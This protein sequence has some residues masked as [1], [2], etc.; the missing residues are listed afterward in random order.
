MQSP[1]EKRVKRYKAETKSH[2]NIACVATVV[3]SG[4]SWLAESLAKLMLSKNEILIVVAQQAMTK[5]AKACFAAALQV[6]E[7]H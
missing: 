3:V 6:L 2:S 7:M 5:S 1:S 4:C